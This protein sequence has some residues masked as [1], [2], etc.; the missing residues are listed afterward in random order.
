MS[1]HD[2]IVVGLG[3]M[4]SAALYQLAKRGVGVLGIDR[5]AP[6]HEQGSSHGDTR[7]TRLAIGEGAHY[8]PLVK[9]SHEIWHDIERETGADLLTQ[10]GELIISSKNRKSSIHVEGFFQNT[11]DAAHAHGVAHELLDASQI[12]T[13]YPQFN[14]RDDEIGYFEAEAGFV[15]P[16]ACIDAELTLARKHGAEIRT[17]ETVLGLDA[18]RN[19]VTVKTD[20]RT[21]QA[22]RLIVAAGAW[23]PKLLGH[24]FDRLFKIYRQV[25]CWFAVEGDVAAYEPERFPVFIWELPVSPQGIYGFP[26]ID[27]ALKVATEQYAATTSPEH[28]DRSVSTEEV[29]NMHRNYI[30]PYLK[31][32]TSNCVKAKAC[33]YTVTPDAGF[34]LDTLPS[35]E[36]VI[37]A[38]CCSGH[39]FKHSAA[40][41]EVLADKAENRA[42]SLDS[43]LFRLGRFSV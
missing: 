9:R 20:H 4:G 27:G 11:V 28:V 24:D 31:G 2:V 23:L 6:P 41:G 34:I 32:V 12:R 8:T 22:D 42:G 13:R 10:C 1:R 29:E 35:S 36:R 38:S 16:E 14:I 43:A 33:L 26:A 39:G 3:A 5:F 21:Y 40:V 25:L 18:G 17:G 15:R 7:V 30:A 37:V 19:G